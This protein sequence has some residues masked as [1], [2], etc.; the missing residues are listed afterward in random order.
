MT[1][2]MKKEN[3]PQK[4]QN[5]SYAQNGCRDY[6]SRGKKKKE[7]FQNF[8]LQNFHYHKNPRNNNFRTSHWTINIAFHFPQNISQYLGKSDNNSIHHSI[9]IN[10]TWKE[11][12]KK[13]VKRMES[14]Q[15][16]ATEWL[17][18]AEM[19]RT[20]RTGVVTSLTL[21]SA[22]SFLCSNLV[23]STSEFGPSLLM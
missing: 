21:S 10:M 14:L 18:P 13:I 16:R 11:T 22:I 19:R 7:D 17:A 8:E 3:C 15:R 23:S 9:K 5:I 6:I 12:C 4:P 20:W 2:A 1:F